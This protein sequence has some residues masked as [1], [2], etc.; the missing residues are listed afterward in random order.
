MKCIKSDAELEQLRSIP[1]GLIYNDFSRMGPSG[2][3]YNILHA[4]HCGQLAKSNL[5]APKYFFHNLDEAITWLHENRGEE[6]GNW[7]RCGVC[8]ANARPASVGSPQ[9]KPALKH[10]STTEQKSAPFREAEVKQILVKYLQGKGYQVRTE[11]LVPSGMVDIVGASPDGSQIMIEVKG[12]DAGG[13]TSAE[14]NF[15]MG[16]GQIISR[17]TEPGSDYA[18]AIPMTGD[19]KRVLKKC[20]GS[21]GFE[22]LG[23]LF[24]V[25]HRDGKVDKY[26]AAA[27][28]AFTHGL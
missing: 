20:K 16:V 28:A 11:V 2:K 6:G 15:Q 25:V 12:E 14:M 27:I 21:F 10:T 1:N 7:K 26:D 9:S 22:R 8:R 24:F 5:N 4:A 17:M 13:Y 23:L 18:L 3:D 19:F